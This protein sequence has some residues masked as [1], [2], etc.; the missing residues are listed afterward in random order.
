MIKQEINGANPKCDDNETE[1][2]MRPS[3]FFTA[4][5]FTP[6]EFSFYAPTA[7]AAAAA[8]PREFFLQAAHAA[9]FSQYFVQRPTLPATVPVSVTSSPPVTKKSGFDVSDLLAKP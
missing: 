9:Q 7:A 3:T 2:L 6:P 5:G 4:N 1:S 8:F